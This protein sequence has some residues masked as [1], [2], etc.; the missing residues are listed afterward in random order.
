MHRL[1]MTLAYDGRAFHGWQ[2]QPGML[3]V[4]GALDGALSTIYQAEIQTAGA[5]RTDAGVHA[6]AQV[7]AFNAPKERDLRKVLNAVNALTP[8]ELLLRDIHDV[9]P[10]FDPRRDAIG[11]HYRY[12]L[13]QGR[14]LPPTLL[15][16]AWA[17]PPLDLQA[18]REAAAAL[19]GEHDFSSFRASD[20]QAATPHRRLDSIT[21]DTAEAPYPARFANESSAL[22]QIDVRGNAFL[23]NMVRILVGSLVEVGRGKQPPSWMSTLLAVCDRTQA[24]PTAIAPGLTL[25]AVHYQNTNNKSKQSEYTP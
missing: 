25:C 15:G 2:R 7:A 21:L 13:W 4:Q 24:G 20:C 11:K 17:V 9:D 6:W 10:S 16:R 3:T 1:R 12:L 18:M 5:S 23:K 14:E 19:H 22:I 8:P